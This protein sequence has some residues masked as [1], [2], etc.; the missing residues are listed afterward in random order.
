MITL[1]EAAKE[2]GIPLVTLKAAC[3]RYQRTGGRSGLRGFKKEGSRNW[4]TTRRSLKNYK[5]NEW[6]ENRGKKPE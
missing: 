1:T 5:N 2:S 6:N 3:Q 4:F